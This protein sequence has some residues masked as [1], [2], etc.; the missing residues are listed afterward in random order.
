MMQGDAEQS[1][2]FEKELT[3]DDGLTSRKLP[4]SIFNAGWYVP[5]RVVDNQ[6]TVPRDG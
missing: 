1:H 4:N 2:G 3:V 5:R 6:P